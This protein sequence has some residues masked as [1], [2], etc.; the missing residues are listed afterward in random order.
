MRACSGRGSTRRHKADSP[1]ADIQR[2][3]TGHAVPPT[4]VPWCDE[5]D[6]GT[7]LPRP[8]CDRMPQGLFLGPLTTVVVGKLDR[9]ARRQRAGS[10]LL[11]RPACDRLPQGLFLG[12]RTPGVARGGVSWPASSVAARR[13]RTSIARNGTRP[14]WPGP[15]GPAASTAGP[16]GRRTPRLPVPSSGMTGAAPWGR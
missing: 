4:A 2:W 14:G 9:I 11:A 10:H 12:P 13:L 3:L 6:S 15:S 5:V 8:A 1:K 16:R 7:T